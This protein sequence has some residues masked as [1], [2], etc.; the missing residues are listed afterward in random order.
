MRTLRYRPW[1][2]DD[3]T[4]ISLEGPAEDDTFSLLAGR[5]SRD[6]GELEEL[7]EE[8]WVEVGEEE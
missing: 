4:W 2:F 8:E 5:T 7:L 1:D 3:W 6:F